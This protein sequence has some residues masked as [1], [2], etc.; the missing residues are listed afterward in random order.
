MA[1]GRRRAR[2]RAAA[3]AVRTYVRAAGARAK[4]G[5]SAA[6]VKQK[7]N[8]QMLMVGG[9]TAAGFGILQRHVKLPAI[10]GLPNTLTY[11]GA[12]VTLG[13]FTGS[14]LL[15]QAGAGPLFAGF[16]RLG[17][18]G[19]KGDKSPADE[20]GG[21]YDRLPSGDATE[22]EFEDVAAGEFDDYAQAS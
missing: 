15:V 2:A 8:A 3:R 13:V 6:A 19:L 4:Q 9:V 18:R 22:G 10:E 17:Y 20:T 11:G 21:E 16:H 5:V 1:K 12:A 7:A 14:N